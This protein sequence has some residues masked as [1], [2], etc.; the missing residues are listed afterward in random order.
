[1]NDTVKFD[2]RIAEE[3]GQQLLISWGTLG[4]ITAG[5]ICGS[6]RRNYALVKDLELVVVPK[7]GPDPHPTPTQMALMGPQAVNEE[8]EDVN[9]FEAFKEEMLAATPLEMGEKD[10]PAYKQFIWQLPQGALKVDTFIIPDKRAWGT[11]V[12][13][14]TGPGLEFNKPLMTWLK[15]RKMHTSGGLLHD[16]PKFWDKEDHGKRGQCKNDQCSKI[17]PC[18]N[19]KD[20]FKAIGLPYI[21]PPG[22]TTDTLAVAIK[23]IELEKRK[24]KHE[25]RY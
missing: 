11:Q 6:V 3:V 21:N 7:F 15:T 5:L 12:M 24:V 10:G 9:L 23:M 13:I 17:I 1:M 19:E 2:H 14:R 25:G 18:Y 16:H 4:M 8:G 20:F 22:R